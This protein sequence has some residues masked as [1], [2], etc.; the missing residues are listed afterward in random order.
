MSYLREEIEKMDPYV[1]GEQPGEDGYLKLNTNENPFPPSPAV[2]QAMDEF[3]SSGALRLYPDPTGG[4]LRRA[5]SKLTGQPLEGVICGNGSDDILAMIMRACGKGG[6]RVVLTY[7]SYSL[8]RVLCQVYGLEFK[9]YDLA[10]GEDFSLPKELYVA[11]GSLL[12]LSTPNAPSGTL[13]P[14]E[15]VEK[16]I[17]GFPGVVVLDEAYID[18][19]ERDHLELLPRHKNLLIV[20]T[21]SKG[22]S[23]ASLRVGYALGDAALIEGLARVKDSY[24]LNA[25]AISVGA[26]ALRDQGHMARNREMVVRQRERLSKELAALGFTVYRSQ[27]NFLLAATPKAGDVYARLKGRR[28]LVRYFKAR[29]LDECLRITV[30]SAKDNELLLQAL[31]ELKK[32]KAF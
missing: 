22:Y 23:L 32:E 9:E 17:K 30:G 13:F 4:E 28:V 27:A 21:L 6:E 14:L 1:P 29:R 7:P 11:R 3:A 8:Y 12:F 26:A 15:A 16:L 20:R 31:K 19:A 5:V 24:N 10:L 18:F 2:K 25:L